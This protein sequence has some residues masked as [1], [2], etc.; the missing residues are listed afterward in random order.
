MAQASLLTAL[1]TFPL[2]ASLPAAMSSPSTASPQPLAAAPSAEDADRADV[3][4][5]LAL[6]YIAPADAELL[7]HLA[8]QPAAAAAAAD[9]RP[10]PL[11]A[12]RVRLAEAARHTSAGAARAAFET[13]FGGI[14]QPAVYVYGSFLLPGRR[15]A[16]KAAR[17]P[18][19]RL[20][21][22]RP[23]TAPGGGRERGPLRHPG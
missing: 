4:G 21:G 11:Q 15:V 1:P 18:A 2:I 5:L 3:W 8:E 10:S 23:G 22:T 13:L 6:L 12:A 20:A 9:A 19:R 16:R 7:R 14:G 17:A